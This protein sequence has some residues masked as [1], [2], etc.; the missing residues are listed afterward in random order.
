MILAGI[1]TEERSYISW[2]KRY[3]DIMLE[4]NS[5]IG[6]FCEH[7]PSSGD[8]LVALGKGSD[9]R[10]HN[11]TCITADMV[12][13]A[14]LLAQSGYPDYWDHVERYVRNFL[15]ANQL[16]LDEKFDALFRQVN[17]GKAPQEVEESLTLAKAQ[18]TGAFPGIV[19]IN[20]LILGEE[21]PLVL[22]MEGCCNW[23]GSRA[24]GRACS[25]VV[26]TKD[27]DTYINMSFNRDTPECQVITHLPTQGQITVIPKK[28]GDFYLRPP[29]W[30]PRQKVRAFSNSI[31]IPVDW[32]GAFV[33]FKQAQKGHEL[34]ITYP[35]VH[36]IQTI[37][38]IGTGKPYTYQLEWLGNTVIAL[39]P[40]GQWLPLYQNRAGILKIAGIE[41]L[42]E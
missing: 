23:G 39:E 30:A 24:V 29:A 27:G 7:F 28:S 12:D 1:T 18:W 21:K 20:D 11:E 15:V 26:T 25:E 34:S 37:T 31:S 13:I 8:R 9:P 35:L 3:Y 32:N 10:P 17:A 4:Q 38:L 14:A 19:G 36:F 41:S 2:G 6:W 42:L 22:D 16:T 5:D 40:K 33:R